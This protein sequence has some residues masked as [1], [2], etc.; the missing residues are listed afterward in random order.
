MKKFVFRILNMS[1][2]LVLYAL[3]IVLTINANIGYGPWEVF[4][5]GL[6][7]QTGSTIGITSIVA[8]IVI[9]IIVTLFKEE[10]GLGTIASMILTGLIIDLVIELNIIPIPS[11]FIIGIIMLVAGLFI[12]SVGSYF[13][14]KAAFGAGPRDNLM[15]VLARITKLP[16]GVCRGIVELVVTFIGWVLGGMVGIGTIISGFAIGFSYK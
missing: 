14:I 4:H 13:Y 9:L 11:N 5:A 2:G 15:V 6:A 3:G 7:K 12:V 1:V 8:G 16:I 10:F